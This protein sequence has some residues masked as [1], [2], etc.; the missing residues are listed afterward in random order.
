MTAYIPELHL[1]HPVAILQTELL[2]PCRSLKSREAIRPRAR[3]SPPQSQ[4]HRV[5]VLVN[6]VAHPQEMTNEKRAY[7]IYWILYSSSMVVR[8]SS[9]NWPDTLVA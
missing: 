8:T 2:T 1:L 6:T 3:L 9:G 7:G 4:N 5:F